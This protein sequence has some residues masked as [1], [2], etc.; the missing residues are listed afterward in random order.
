MLKAG[1]TVHLTPLPN[2]LSTKAIFKC[3]RLAN[4]SDD[5]EE[6]THLPATFGSDRDRH[7]QSMADKDPR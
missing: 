4:H 5:S 2:G 7:L 1:L 3:V 6:Q